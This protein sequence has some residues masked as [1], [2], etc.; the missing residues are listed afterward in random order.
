M[1][2][3]YETAF[4]KRPNPLEEMIPVPTTLSEKIFIMLR[5]L[6]KRLLTKA[7]KMSSPLPAG[8]ESPNHRETTMQMECAVSNEIVKQKAKSNTTPGFYT[9]THALE[10]SQTS[11]NNH[12]GRSIENKISLFK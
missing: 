6:L 3:D 7:R 10:N 4:L 11:T 1:L 9:T 2:I 12:V 5:A 8:S